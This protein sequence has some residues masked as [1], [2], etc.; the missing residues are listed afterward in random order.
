MMASG[1]TKATPQPSDDHRRLAA[2]AGEWAGEEMIYPSPF[3]EPGPAVSHVVARV[4]LNGFCV[5]QDYR[6]MR[7]GQQIFAGHGV[8]TF[9]RDDRLFKL[10]WHDSLGY[11]ATAPASGHWKDGTLTLLRGSLRGAARHIFTFADDD[12]YTLKIQ[13]SPDAEGWADLLS[14]VYRRLH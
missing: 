2:F 1:A 3:F 14:G 13:F 6:Q 10:F 5:I 11:S 12:T 9:D 7:Q 4:D 8:F